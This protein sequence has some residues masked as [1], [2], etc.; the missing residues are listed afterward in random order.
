SSTS[1]SSSSA[2]T[3]HY[4]NISYSG[5]GVNTPSYYSKSYAVG[6]T[7]SVTSPEV[8]GYTADAKVV[9]G[10][11]ENSDINVSVYYTVNSYKL[12]ITYTGAS[13]Q[14]R[15][16]RVNYGDTY[17][18]T[19]PTVVGYV[20]D[21]AVVSGTMD[22]SDLNVTV[23]YSAITY[24]ISY[25]YN[26]G[27]KGTTNPTTATYDKAFTVSSPTKSGYKFAGWQVAN[28]N[29]D[30]ALYGNSATQD[31]KVLS[32]LSRC[33]QKN[34]S[35][36]DYNG[37][38]YWTA[39]VYFKNLTATNNATIT[40]KANWTYIGKIAD[41]NDSASVINTAN[42][43]LV[44]SKVI[45]IANGVTGDFILTFSYYQNAIIDETNLA[46]SSTCWRTGILGIGKY[47][48]LGYY[49]HIRQDGFTW[50]GTN[51][52]GVVSSPSN[53]TASNNYG[54]MFYGLAGNNSNATTTKFAEFV[55]NSL[56]TYKIVGTKVGQVG[57]SLQITQTIVSLGKTY[58]NQTVSI[59]YDVNLTDG[60][61][62][63][64]GLDFCVK[65]EDADLSFESLSYV[66]TADGYT[67]NAKDSEVYGTLVDGY[68]HYAPDKYWTGDFDFTFSYNQ[69]QANYF[70]S[71]ADTCW[72]TG[73]V[74]F[75]EWGNTSERVIFRNDW[76]GEL[77]PNATKITY[78]NSAVKSVAD[79]KTATTGKATSFGGSQIAELRLFRNASITVRCTRVGNT[80]TVYQYISSPGSSEVTLLN[81]YKFTTTITNLSFQVVGRTSGITVTYED[82][83]ANTKVLKNS[84]L[85]INTYGLGTY[86]FS[87]P[88]NTRVQ[89]AFP[90]KVEKGT[91]VK[92]KGSTSYFFSVLELKEYLGVLDG[93]NHSDNILLDSK[94]IDTTAIKT[95]TVTQDCYIAVNMR[96]ADNTTSFSGTDILQLFKD[97]IEV[98][99]N[100][101]N[102]INTN[103]KTFT[104]SMMQDNSTYG[105]TTY[106]GQF[107][108]GDTRCHIAVIPLIKKG[109]VITFSG[110]T[111]YNWSVLE[112]ATERI[113]LYDTTWQ[114]PANI[115]SYT[116]SRDCYIAINVKYVS[117]A[118]FSGV[119]IKTFLYNNIKIEGK[120][121]IVNFEDD[122]THSATEPGDM[123]SINHRGFSST[124][125]ENTIAAYSV[126]KYKGFTKV[127]CDINFTSDGYGVLLHDGSIDRTSDGTG[128]INSVNFNTVRGYDFGSWKSSTYANEQMP[129]VEEFLIQCK[130]LQLHPYLELKYGTKAQIQ[131]LALL[132]R[133]YGMEDNVT[134]ISFDLNC[135]TYVRDVSPGA[136]LGFLHSDINQDVINS[137]NSLKTGKNEV[138]LDINY[139]CVDTSAEATNRVD[140]CKANN[141]PLEVWTVNDET[142]MK[143]VY[144]ATGGYVTGFTSDNTIAENVN[145]G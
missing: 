125:P 65:A 140:L 5:A 68:K 100:F 75:Y 46:Y 77:G 16:Q 128:N 66:I 69:T 59:V 136:R 15:T 108:E 118:S 25:D 40:L 45:E 41:A 86:C 135:L 123:Q 51:P 43:S 52:I 23:K 26:G 18:V 131:R 114:D 22:D 83:G 116:V 139:G 14:E 94:W 34:T 55:S 56:V 137:A 3:Y 110:G 107:G 61:L 2:V 27:T 120:C 4:L 129:T 113:V 92:F 142:T 141:L 19:S 82:Y 13:V 31:A 71:W 143:N 121:G 90:M 78:D 144:T 39:D 138:F 48:D 103:E 6:E 17:S 47:T 85:A 63:N 84:S 36:L 124:A 101:N 126:S 102:N 21:K 105:L 70:S 109:T 106:S 130:N 20:A 8:K 44:N 72:R 96:Y 134:W 37:S 93:V 30:T 73:Y 49:N 97:S 29:V 132:V 122:V 1:S 64:T 80:V 50:Q 58:K 9:S 87:N 111:T 60:I 81:I 67:Y 42:D 112:M 10:V 35:D 91:T 104:S 145:F 95:Y 74:V 79:L 24:N 53:Y 57:G 117:G 89:M 115:T 28:V 11:M 133:R 7:Y 12:T 33:Y 98:A 76:H 88:A 38:A 127:E 119:D 54:E 62:L 32:E 99:I